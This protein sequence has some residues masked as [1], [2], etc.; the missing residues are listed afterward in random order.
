[1]NA[2]GPTECSDD[3]THHVVTSADCAA[4]DWAPIG[5]EIINTHLYVV[6]RSGAV[7]PDGAEGELLVGGAGVG[8]GY[9]GAPAATAPAFVPDYLSG[10]PGGRL[11]R[12]GDRCAGPPTARWTT[13]AAATVRSSSGATGSS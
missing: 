4:G 8:R 3:V 1:M 11:Y 10:E 5:R 7:V 6:D 13:L 9:L 12:T 2:Y